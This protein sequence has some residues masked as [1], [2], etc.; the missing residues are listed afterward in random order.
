MS[1]VHW[2][3]SNAEIT[4]NLLISKFSYMIEQELQTRLQDRNI[5]TLLTQV[6]SNPL[7]RTALTIMC[8]V[9]TIN[10][11]LLKNW[12][13]G[14]VFVYSLFSSSIQTE[15][16]ADDPAFKQPSKFVGRVYSTREVC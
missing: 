7:L 12:S 1:L 5:G 2:A 10:K 3:R 9:H 6:G 8:C 4:I 13:R 14:S 15:V 16:R 11:P